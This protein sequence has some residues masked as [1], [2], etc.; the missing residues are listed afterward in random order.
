M[1]LVGPAPPGDVSRYAQV[2]DNSDPEFFVD[3]MD[4]FRALPAL[5][6]LKG[7]MLEALAPLPGQRVLDVGCGP[8]DDVREIAAHLTPGGLAVGLDRSEVML[9]VARRRSRESQ[10][11]VEFRLG[12]ACALPF[13]DNVFDAV[14]AERTLVHVDDPAVAVGEMAR[15]L[16]SRGRMVIFE[17]DSEGCDVA[18]VDEPLMRTMSCCFASRVTNAWVGRGL[19]ELCKAAGLT[20]VQVEPVDLVISYACYVPMMH[21]LLQEAARCGDVGSED[22]SAFFAAMEQSERQGRFAA[23]GTGWMVTAVKR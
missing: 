9:D 5:V 20:D 16:R 17:G 14:R 23:R 4:R 22:V 11:P 15:V 10:L 19:P 13:A 12:D 2:D 8:G 3:L 6:A 18:G 7:R 1:D 21:G